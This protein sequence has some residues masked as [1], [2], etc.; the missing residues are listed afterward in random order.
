MQ[1]AVAGGQAALAMQLSLPAGYASKLAEWMLAAWNIDDSE[2]KHDSEG[3]D[4]EKKI[5][6]CLN[7]FHEYFPFNVHTRM[8]WNKK[9]P[10][11]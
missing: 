6:T 9:N 1:H 2:F 4:S 11:S 5:Q 7:L 8:I 3:S 10:M